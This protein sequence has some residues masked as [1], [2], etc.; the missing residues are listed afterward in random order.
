MKKLLFLLFAILLVLG[1][2]GSPDSEKLGTSDGEISEDDIDN[3]EET[4]EEDVDAEEEEDMT[5]L[6]TK[7]VNITKYH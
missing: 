5:D 1:A 3:V 6:K 7:E 2:C 4:D